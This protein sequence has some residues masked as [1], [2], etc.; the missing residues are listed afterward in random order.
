MALHR[1]VVFSQVIVLSAAFALSALGQTDAPTSVDDRVIV[2]L[3]AEHPQVVT[4]TGITV[5][6]SG[7]VFVVESHTHFRPDD[8]EGPPADRI[9]VLEDTTG[10]GRA[11]KRQV[12]HEGFTHVMDI[13]FH[14]DGSLYVATRMDIHRLRDT[15]GD[16][17]ANDITPIVTMDTTGT[18]PHNGISG[19]AFDLTGE[20]NF[21]LGEN[22]GHAYTLRGTDG[23]AIS[24]GGEGGSTYHVRADGSQ[25]RRVSTGWW[26][27]FGMC[28]DAFGRVFGTD[29]DPGASPP[30]RLIQVIEGGDY[31]YQYR[32]GRTGLHPLITW[33]GNMPGV[34]PMVAGT[35]E[36][37][38]AV[39][40]YESTGL[41]REYLGD[42]L[43]ASWA[44]HRVER[45]TISESSGDGLVQTQRGALISGGNDFR[46]VGL[47][48]A[49]DGSLLVSDWVL[50]SYQLHGQGR[51]WRVYDPDMRAKK[52]QPGSPQRAILSANR[53]ERESA[54]RQLVRS[55]NGRRRLQ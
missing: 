9:L 8:Y 45:Y 24:G 14:H 50:S 10:D 13:E 26:N 2:E 3:F 33:T 52:T 18:Y 40:A 44:D 47:A 5:H 43:V 1:I 35:G 7:R 55:K 17:Q 22:L 30:C 51:V 6:S 39:I 49:P 20:L 31:G 16:W 11:D 36:A 53:V 27:P 23:V 21:G 19:L 4:P 28:V 37:P 54:A 15:N 42:L 46:P 34:L 32:Y 48:V 29:N 12:F 38:C 25:L 41:P